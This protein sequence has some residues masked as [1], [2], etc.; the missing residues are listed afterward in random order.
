MDLVE[1]KAM[2]TGGS[3]GI[4]FAIAEALKKG[5]AAVAITGRKESDLEDAARQIDAIAIQADVSREEDC[6]KSVAE[7]ARKLGGLNV[8]VNNAG[9]GYSSPLEGIETG[10]FGDVWATNVL[11]PTIMARE[12]AKIFKEQKYGNIINISSSSGVRGYE[13]GSPYVATKFAL[14]GM[15]ECWRAELRKYNVRVILINPSE[16][17]TGFGRRPVSHPNPRKLVAEDIAHTVVFCL[18]MDDRGFIPEVS[19]WATNP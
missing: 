12:A 8:L 10:P 4:G 16:V 7:A 6:R 9:I 18:T 17:Q 5:G 13:N 3:R 2:V 15:T 19:I 1:C 14:R 11:G